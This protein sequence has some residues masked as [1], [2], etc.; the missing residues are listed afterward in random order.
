MRGCGGVSMVEVT[1]YR[2]APQILPPPCHQ[3]ERNRD[4][5]V[6]ASGM[7]GGWLWLYAQRP[8]DQR[9]RGAGGANPPPRLLESQSST[10]CHAAEAEEQR[11][12]MVV[13]L[14]TRLQI[15]HLRPQPQPQPQ[16]KP[17]TRS[18]GAVTNVGW[19]WAKWFRIL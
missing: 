10:Q 9:L 19:T 12:A 17:Q 11:R 5:P 16:P 13:Q 8:V 2:R 1:K 14:H 7:D 15:A 4:R 18:L 3:Q 6:K